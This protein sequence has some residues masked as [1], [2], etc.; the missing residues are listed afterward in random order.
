AAGL[1]EIAELDAVVLDTRP[2]AERLH[3]L[4]LG[5]DV[6]RIGLSAFERADLLQKIK[7]ENNF[8][9]SE[10]AAAASMKQPLVSKLL[11]LA[12]LSVEIRGVLQGVDQEKCY[13]I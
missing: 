6:H 9:V 8:T 13:I 5:V 1:V 12:A 11:P 10:L 2:P 4:Q 7:T 3:L